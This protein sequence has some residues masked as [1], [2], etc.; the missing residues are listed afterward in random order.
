MSA[1][2]LTD[3]LDTLSADIHRANVEAG[4]YKASNQEHPAVKLCLIHS[5]VSETLEGVRKG[6]PAEHIEGFSAEEEEMADVFIRAL[7]YC[8]W[9]DLRIGAAVRAKLAYNRVRP[10]HKPEARAAEGG[11]KF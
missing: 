3:A 1:A 10:D 9:R 6:L 4:W 11:K 2:M 7:D 5:E 8:G